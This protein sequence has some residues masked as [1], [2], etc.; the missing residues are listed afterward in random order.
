[1]RKAVFQI[2]QKKF[3]DENEFNRLETASNSS[4][5]V[6]RERISE[7]L[8][9]VS[10]IQFAREVSANIESR[11]LLRVINI[12]NSTMQIASTNTHVKRYFNNFFPIIC[13]FRNYKS[14]I[15]PN[16]FSCSTETMSKERFDGDLIHSL[17]LLFSS[18]IIF[19]DSKQIVNATFFYE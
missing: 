5:K 11:F 2:F 1:M 8:L 9:D 13:K 12:S 14:T 3:T 18:Q 15:I 6:H 4:S 19:S 7:V 17:G 10:I 16:D